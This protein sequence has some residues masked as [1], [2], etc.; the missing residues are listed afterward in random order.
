MES[1]I[2]YSVYFVI[3]FVCWYQNFRT[4]Y[5]GLACFNAGCLGF[6]LCYML[7]K[8]LNIWGV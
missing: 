8:A 7:I 2:W 6:F 3:S 1:L 5:Y 4:R